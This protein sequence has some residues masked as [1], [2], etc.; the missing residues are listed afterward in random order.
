MDI[1]GTSHEEL[2]ALL[3]NIPVFNGLEGA[4]MIQIVPLLRKETFPAES[5]IIR[6]GDRG[7]SMYVIVNGV[8][9]VARKS[10]GGEEISLQT[11]QGGA[12][13]GE[14]SLIDNL[15]RS[16]TVTAIIET[17]IFT[18]QKSDFDELLARNT[19][20]ANVFYRNCLTETF[21]RFRHI[22]ANFTFSQH[23]LHTKTAQLEEINLDLSYAKRIQHCFIDSATLDCEGSLISG[24]RHSYIYRPCLEVGGDFLNIAKLG[25]GGL[26]IIIA[27]VVGHGITA[28]LST[29]VLKSG[30]SLFLRESAGRPADLMR[31]INT[32]FAE[33]LSHVYATCYCA[34]VSPDARR[35]TFAKG[36][37]HH[38][39]FWSGSSG[40]FVEIDCPGP[41]IGISLSSR[42]PQVEYKLG[43][44]DRL[45]FFTDGV[46]EQH[47]RGEAMYT[48]ERLRKKVREIIRSGRHN[49][50]NAIMEDLADFAGIRHFEDDVTMLLLEFD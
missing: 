3:K 2:I 44:G 28:A 14:F 37:H 27:D 1:Q 12:F 30:Y 46:I 21:S 9:R 15:P 5:I 39:L 41:G 33:T 50:L 4:E 22:V 47:G 49:M 40:D 20:L 32:H 7:E 24:V 6:E 36:G 17:E 18:L 38:P 48:E 35:V 25:D 13:F 43:S 23:S 31:A 42:Y 34:H 10:E 16:A 11:L 45:L 8:V 29:G 26:S 19:H